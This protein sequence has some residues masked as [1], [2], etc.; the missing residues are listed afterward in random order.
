MS[1]PTAPSFDATY[2]NLLGVPYRYDGTAWHLDTTSVCIGAT[3]IQGT[4]GIAGYTGIQGATLPGG[5]DGDVLTFTDASSIPQRVIPA[6]YAQL[7]SDFT[8]AM[9]LGSGYVNHS[10]ADFT[11]DVYSATTFNLSVPNKMIVKDGGDGVYMV[12]FSLACKSGNAGRI[13]WMVYK[14]GTQSFQIN[15]Y[16]ESG[17][18]LAKYWANVQGEGMV[19]LVKDSTLELYYYFSSVS[20]Y[21]RTAPY[22]YFY[23]HRISR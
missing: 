2:Q 10:F 16:M 21:F 18:D 19:S 8:T 12:G 1:F 9:N 15:N 14:D 22:M 11:A 7:R 4:T 20:T 6:S 23:A 5:A 17:I 3:G 13:K